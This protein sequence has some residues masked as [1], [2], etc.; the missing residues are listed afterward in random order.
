MQNPNPNP[1]NKIQVDDPTVQA[2]AKATGERA[3]TIAAM[4]NQQRYRKEYNKRKQREMKAL[5]QLIKQHPELLKDQ[6]VE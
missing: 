2:L 6:E 4:I 1:I 5:R 3:E